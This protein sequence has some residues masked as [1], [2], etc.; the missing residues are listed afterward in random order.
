MLRLLGLVITIGL[1]D[2]IN[3][4]TIAP[5]LYLSAGDRARNRVMEFTLAVFAVYLFGG[6]LF[7]L[8]PGQLLRSLLP[9]LHHTVRDVAEIVAGVVL[10]AAAAMTWRNRGRLIERGMPASNPRAR[11]SVLLGATITAIELPTAFPYFAA[12]AAIAGSGLDVLGQLVLLL[13][14]NVCFV[15]PLIGIVAVLTFAP[16]RSGRMLGRGR[17]F[18][19]RRWPQTLAILLV[20]IGLVALLIGATGIIARAN[21][22]FPRVIRHIRTFLHLPR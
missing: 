11:S 15:L 20:I 5:A 13:V 10:L 9:H 12:I 6:A 2:S 19:E 16:D 3:P 4:S 18:L 8:G 22:R 17:D 21:G 7:A 1:A 14:F